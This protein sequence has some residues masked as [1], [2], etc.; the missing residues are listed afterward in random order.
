M[1]GL[2]KSG[3]TRPFTHADNCKILKADPTVEIQWSEV[4]SG[5]WEAVCAC[6]S[7]HF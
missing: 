7:E 5:Y 4:E 2:K 3:P 1:F 6:G